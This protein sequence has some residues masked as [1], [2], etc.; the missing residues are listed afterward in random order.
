MDVFVRMIAV[1]SGA[2]AIIFS[3]KVN[4]SNLEMTPDSL[5]FQSSKCYN[6]W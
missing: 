6:I 4:Q 1:Y 5:Q 3:L 2:I